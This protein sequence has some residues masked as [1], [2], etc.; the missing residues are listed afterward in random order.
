MEIIT[1]KPYGTNHIVRESN[2]SPLR[3]YVE[4]YKPYPIIG[5]KYMVVFYCDYDNPDN[6]VVEVTAD[7]IDEITFRM[8]DPDNDI[9]EYILVGKQVHTVT[10]INIIENVLLD[11]FYFDSFEDAYEYALNLN[12][13]LRDTPIRY[14]V[15]T[16]PERRTANGI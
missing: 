12:D 2:L 14:K 3:K 16:T 4:V 1:Y 7:N 5:E 6:Y 10:C 8:N 15:T 9:T 13:T 11:T